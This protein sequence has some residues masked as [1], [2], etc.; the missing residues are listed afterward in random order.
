MVSHQT[1]IQKYAK[2][3]PYHVEKNWP[4]YLVVT[5]DDEVVQTLF[6]EKGAN[7]LCSL[8]NS[9]RFLG[10]IDGLN[11]GIQNLISEN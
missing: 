10:F 11:A 4:V 1:L 7:E 9:N 2:K 6:S 5:E 8:L 3:L